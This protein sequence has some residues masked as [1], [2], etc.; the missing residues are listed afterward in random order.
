MNKNEQNNSEPDKTQENSNNSGITQDTKQP[1]DTENQ[2]LAPEQQAE[3]EKPAD[4]SSIQEH[5][6]ELV[7][8][9][10]IIEEASDTAILEQKIA[11]L[12]DELLRARAE[13]DNIHRRSA[14]EV[15]NAKKFALE[16]LVTNLL[17]VIDSLEQSIL[18]IRDNSSEED[19]ANGVQLCLKLLIT[20]LAKYGVAQIEA[21]GAKFNP[22]YHEAMSTVVA[23]DIQ[24]GH[25]A[26]VL[27]NGF[28]LNGRLLRASR[29]LIA[30]HAELE[31]KP[32]SEAE[33]EAE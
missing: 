25:V 8:P 24:P 12:S 18:F 10:E 7:S 5:I 32:E 14:R 23:T 28:T 22:E 2:T 21:M 27:Q 16:K 13:V 33:S 15:A 1:P 17:P 26:Q 6:S 3:V 29:V 31:Q 19:T 20:T 30:E 11:I 9:L 4:N